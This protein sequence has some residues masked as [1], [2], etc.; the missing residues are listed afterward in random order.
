MIF[1]MGKLLALLFVLGISTQQSAFAVPRSSVSLGSGG[2]GV[3]SIEPGESSF[4]NPATLVHLKGRHFFST[5]QKDLWAVSA[6]ENVR[7]TPLPGALTYFKSTQNDQ[8]AQAFGLSFS[9]FAY[10]KFS[11]GMTVNY[12]QVKLDGDEERRSST[13][14]GNIG[15]AWSLNPNFGIGA[16]FENIVDTPSK[17]SNTREM[18]PRSRFGMNYIYRGWLRT[19]VDFVT[20]GN[21]DFEAMTPQL[22]FETYMGK[23]FIVRTG[24]NKPQ[25]LRES[26]SAG[27]GL[28]LPK[29]RLDYASAWNV[30]GSKES[31]HSIDLAVPF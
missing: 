25:N 28:D 14:N 22:G 11:V 13:F 18:D 3:A 30:E 27:A 8:D 26:W 9:E 29:F 2:G 23:Y 10:K 5:F 21:N 20:S 24:W 6:T 12:W 16:A 7:D 17:F 19:R 15:L 4:M 31:R 1:P